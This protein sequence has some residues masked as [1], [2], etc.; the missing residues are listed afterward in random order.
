MPHFRKTLRLLTTIILIICSFYLP[1]SQA[2]AQSGLTFLVNST[3]DLPDFA[4]NTVCSAGHP[5]DGPCTL[6]AAVSEA[7]ANIN[8]SPVTILIQPGTYILSILPGTPDDNHVGDLDI[9]ITTSSNPITIQSTEGKG[10]VILT[11]ATEFTDRILEIG[12]GANVL[13]KD[14]TFSGSHLVLNSST[15]GGGAILNFGVLTLESTN[16]QNNSVTCAPGFSCSWSVIGGAILNYGFF[17]I[18]DANFEGNSAERGFAIFNA[19]GS[20]GGQVNSSLFAENSGLSV[21]TITNFSALTIIN[22]T[23]S[24]NHTKT[25]A[26]GIANDTGGTLDVYSSTFANQGIYS[27]IYNNAKVHVS[28]CIFL[29]EPDYT[30][31]NTFGVWTSGGYNIYSDASW[32][33]AIGIG[34]L[35]NTDPLLGPLTNNG[36]L[37]K[38]Y[39]FLA[40]S[41][42][43]NHR[44]GNCAT[45]T[46]PIVDDQR[47]QPRAD[48]SCDT[49]AY[50]LGRTYLPTVI[51]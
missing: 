45:P 23:F 49:G 41:P 16:F 8:T 47:H 28:D 17:M 12:Y 9:T 4:T 35:Q 51:R 32:P 40:N 48:G 26:A 2:R 3:E 11:T 24:G 5:T 21:G 14:I 15:A 22:S 29:A 42:A 50:E 43:I 44:P 7:N 13:I 34:D 38:T 6:R 31:F 30:N 18:K 36:G 46:A 25:A 37:T 19:G 20:T 1:S 10:S 27:S 33:A 39:A